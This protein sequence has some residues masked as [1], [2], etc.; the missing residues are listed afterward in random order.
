MKMEALVLQVLMESADVLVSRKDIYEKAWG[1]PYVNVRENTVAMHISKL[2]RKMKDD[3]EISRY[4]ET[5]WGEIPLP[6]SSKEWY[7]SLRKYV[8]AVILCY[9]LL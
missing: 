1:L 8:Q 5:K 7:L 3:G 6:E 9:N 4:I 2:R